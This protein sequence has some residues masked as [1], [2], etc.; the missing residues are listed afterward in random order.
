MRVL[1]LHTR[2]RQPGGEDAVVAAEAAMLRAAGHEVQALTAQNPSGAR[3]GLGALALSSWN[4]AARR[5]AE[6]VARDLRP[7]VAHVHNTWYA[8]SPSVLAGL[9]AAGV[10]VVTT[11][12]NYRLACANALLYRDGA[13]CTDCVGASPWQGVRHR[14][15][16]GSV[17][18]SA[19]AASNIALHGA[20]GTWAAHVRVFLALTEFARATFV[21]AGLPSSAILVRPNATADPGPRSTPP[22]A[23]RTVLWV[24]RLV[25]EKGVDILLEAWR[26]RAHPPDLDG[27][28]NR[29]L[30]LVIVGDGPQRGALERAAPPRVR[31]IG[32]QPPERVRDLLLA[33]RALVFP[34]RWYEGQPMAVLEA[35]AAGVPVLAA[36]LG[37]LAETVAPVGRRWLLPPGDAAAW[38]RGLAL[39]ADGAEV[40]AAGARARRV[41]EQRHTPRGAVASLEH[42]YALAIARSTAVRRPAD[43]ARPR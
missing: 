22:S 33:A 2:Y 10:P 24:G 7:D 6:R 32:A 20:A 25:P 28:V 43:R 35:F 14:C 30:E 34:S 23:S 40:D 1:Q 8:M 19:A 5:S 38:A 3:A 41:Y 36:D 29:E 15:Y 11:L 18:Q 13:P 39:L 27:D 4:P 17:L 26:H 21:A 9:S 12:H 16:R 37:G 42:A 31:L